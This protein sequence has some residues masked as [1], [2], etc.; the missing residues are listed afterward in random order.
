LAGG[1]PIIVVGTVC[2][3]F[4]LNFFRLFLLFLRPVKVAQKVL[5]VGGD[6]EDKEEE[7]DWDFDHRC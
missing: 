2:L 7:P 1:E 3:K 6:A 5:D 4:C